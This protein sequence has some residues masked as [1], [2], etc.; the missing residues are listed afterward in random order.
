MNKVLIIT[1]LFPTS[2]RMPGLAKYLPEF[3]WEP[4]ILI[5]S[6]LGKPD[7]QLRIMQTPYQDALGFWKRLFRLNSD[8]PIDRQVKKRFGITSKKSPV[9]SILTRIAEVVNYPDRDKDWKPFAIRA[10]NKLLQ[11]EKIDVIIS[12]S[13]PVTSHLIAKELKTRYRIPWIA[14]LRDLWSQNHNYAYTRLRRYFDRR[15]EIKTLSTADALSTVSQPWADKLSA[16]HN[17]KVTH[18][19]TNGFSPESIN[20]PV[21]KLTNKFTITYTGSIYSRK[22]DPLKLFTALRDLIAERAIDTDDIEV[23]L[24][25]VVAGWLETEIEKYNLTGIVNLYGRVPKEVA[26]QKQRE[27]QVLFITKWNDPEELGAYSGKIFEYLAA[28]RPIL[29]IDGSKDV[30]TGLLNETNSGI[31]APTVEDIKEALLKLY[32]DYKQRGESAYNGID[33]EISKYSYREMARKFSEVLE[34]LIP[35]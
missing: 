15:L 6:L 13:A 4:I 31:D 18:S 24:Y 20:V 30:V 34:R 26:L 35:E 25:G 10:G 12:S 2:P 3:G 1:R 17:G 19:I 28:R 7:R 23:R 14:D 16:L 9:D 21:A 8:E 22:H 27:S 11:K 33:S 29:A 32:Q 5:P